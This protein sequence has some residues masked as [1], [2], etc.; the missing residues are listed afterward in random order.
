M[1]HAGVAGQKELVD[2]GNY[3]AITDI[4]TARQLM[5]ENCDLTIAD[6]KFLPNNFPVYLQKHSAYTDAVSKV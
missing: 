2:G 1:M 3:A 5:L 4:S 6:Q